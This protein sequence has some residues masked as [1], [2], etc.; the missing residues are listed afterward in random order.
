MQQNF[1]LSINITNYNFWIYFSK[2]AVLF[3]GIY[4]K[5]SGA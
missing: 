2:R 3:D 4:R 5:K 1:K